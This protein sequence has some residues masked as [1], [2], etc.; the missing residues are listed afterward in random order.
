M[1]TKT[2][3]NFEDWLNNDEF[4]NSFLGLTDED[5]SIE[6]LSDEDAIEEYLNDPDPDTLAEESCW[7]TGRFTDCNCEICAH[8]YECSGYEDRD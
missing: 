5:L 2:D 3:S 1:A 6:V 4:L 7:A 8:K